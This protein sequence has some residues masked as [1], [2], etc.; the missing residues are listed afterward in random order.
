MISPNAPVKSEAVL[1]FT[2]LEPLGTAIDSDFTPSGVSSKICN[3]CQRELPI[4]S[5][6]KHCFNRDGRCGKCRSC[7][8]AQARQR[9]AANPE[10][11]Q[12]VKRRWRD[13][14]P[15][16]VRAYYRAYSKAEKW[17][18]YHRNYHQ[19]KQAAL[20]ASRPPREKCSCG[21][22]DPK[23]FQ[24]QKDRWVCW[25]CVKLA[26]RPARLARDRAR[27]RIRGI[28]MRSATILRQHGPAMQRAYVQILELHPKLKARVR[29]EQFLALALPGDYRNLSKCGIHKVILLNRISGSHITNIGW[30]C[31]RCPTHAVDQRFFDID[32]ILARSLG[33]NGRLAN[34]QILC[35]NCH[36]LKTIS[37]RLALDMRRHELGGTAGNAP[38]PLSSNNNTPIPGAD[39]GACGESQPLESA[40][41]T[42]QDSAG[43]NLRR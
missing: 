6:D 14:N 23:R 15:E 9:A 41:L 33:G 29:V 27:N 34:L 12:A 1:E 3:G 16:R 43:K 4:T 40:C 32:H 13:K 28:Q 35:P 7:V 17:V 25:N 37:D 8:Q 11:H 26:S 22:D 5:F 19:K 36:R 10:K 24:W 2:P 18:Q 42:A 21:N 38:A 30:T 20:F 39:P 31:A